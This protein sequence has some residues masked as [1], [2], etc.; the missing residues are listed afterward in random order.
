MRA[1][2]R[3]ELAIQRLRDEARSLLSALPEAERPVLGWAEGPGRVRAIGASHRGYACGFSLRHG[4]GWSE[5][6][7]RPYLVFS[8][9]PEALL[10]VLSA[11]AGACGVCTPCAQGR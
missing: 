10:S 1:V 7:V 3:P 11:P 9:G 2:L 4:G 5:W 8:V 6:I